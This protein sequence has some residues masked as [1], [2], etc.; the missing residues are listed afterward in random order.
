MDSNYDKDIEELRKKIERQDQII[1]YLIMK[2]NC[3]EQ[4]EIIQ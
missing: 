4:K 3:Y 2:L 1:T